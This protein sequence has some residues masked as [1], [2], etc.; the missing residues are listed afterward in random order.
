[1]LYLLSGKNRPANSYPCFK[2]Q[3]NNGVSFEPFF[4]FALYY[5]LPWLLNQDHE[6]LKP[7]G[8]VLTS[9][10]PNAFILFDPFVGVQK[11]CSR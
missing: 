4:H 1:M 9:Y 8:N 6:L 11:L 5:I 10:F 3:L 7:S 2:A